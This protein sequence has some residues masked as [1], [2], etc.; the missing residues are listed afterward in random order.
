MTNNGEGS[1]SS[2]GDS[3]FDYFPRALQIQGTRRTEGMMALGRGA[4]CQKIELAI[5]SPKNFSPMP[6]PEPCPIVLHYITLDV[7]TASRE[8]EE[9]DPAMEDPSMGN[10]IIACTA[11]HRLLTHASSHGTCHSISELTIRNRCRE[12]AGYAHRVATAAKGG[13]EGPVRSTVQHSQGLERPIQL[14]NLPD[15]CQLFATPPSKPADLPRAF[16]M[17]AQGLD[18]RSV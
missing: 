18:A 14:N 5:P 9:L 8:G 2:G 6:G 7:T 3:S 12:R 16:P 10:N 13:A 11:L 4:W 1:S 15:T 17:R